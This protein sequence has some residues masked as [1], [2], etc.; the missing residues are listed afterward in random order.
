MSEEEIAQFDALSNLRRNGA[1]EKQ[2]EYTTS[3]DGA[4]K[5][6]LE[7]VAPG[8]YLVTL[9][10]SGYVG[11]NERRREMMVTVQAGQDLTGLTYK[12]QAAGVIAGRIVDAEGDP[13]P[14]VTVQV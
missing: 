2:Q 3:T 9:S 1:D 10:R 6:K 11:A 12:L 14:H 8:K 5:F 13:L 7:N 4:G